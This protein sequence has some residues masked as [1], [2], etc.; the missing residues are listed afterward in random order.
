MLVTLGVG[1]AAVNTG[2][3]LL[4]LVLGLLL[5]SIVLSGIASELVLRKLSIERRFPRRA[6]AGTAAP[7]E[8]V[9]RNEKRWLSSYSIELEDVAPDEPTDRRCYFLKVGPRS[10]QSATYHRTLR[11]RGPLAFTTVLVRTRYPF[12]LFEKMRE[13]P[14]EAEL[15]V[16]PALAK[17]AHV[18]LDDGPGHELSD[19]RRGM[20]SE[21]SGLREYIEGDDARDIHWRRTA[22]LGRVVVRERHRDAAPRVTL[23]VDERMPRDA[24]PEW[25]E[26]FERK[27]SE[28]AGA[29]ARAV[30][31]G[32]AVRVVARSGA[33]PL[34]LSGRPPDPI[35]RF[36]ALLEPMSE[37]EFG[38][39]EEPTSRLDADRGAA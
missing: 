20:G 23:N 16:Y 9:L 5:S 37:S 39:D 25:A 17:V 12:G 27:L 33:S 30:A 22:A 34:V 8:L 18:V 10:E 3:N 21:V 26:R 29:A 24:G 15:L 38:A 32:A 11:R 2:H 1:A 36:L 14:L 31:E 6:F 4:Y 35:W 13:V 19:P 7:V 28:T